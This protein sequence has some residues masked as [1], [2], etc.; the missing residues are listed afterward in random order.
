M[1][2]K[3]ML[4]NKKKEKE[5]KKKRRDRDLYRPQIITVILCQRT[6]LPCKEEIQFLPSNIKRVLFSYTLE[7]YYW[8]SIPSIF[9]FFSFFLYL[10]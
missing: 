7:I 5:E 9:F 4:E 2:W 1:K 6:N 10:P 3:E 8:L